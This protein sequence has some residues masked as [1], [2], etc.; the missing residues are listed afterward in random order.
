MS[1]MEVLAGLGLVA[2]EL[3]KY[4]RGNYEF[5]QD[6]RFEREECRLKMQIE[7]FQLFR[8]DIRD[9]VELTVGKMDLYHLIGA[10]FL[11]M[12]VLYYC[13]G[14]FEKTPPPFL[15]N[16]YYLSNAS[17]WVYLMLAIWLAMHASISSH[18]YGTRLLT[19]FVRL[20]IPGSAQLNVLNARYADFEKQG[21]QM[22]RVP[23]VGKEANTWQQRQANG[24][25]AA[26]APKSMDRDSGGSKNRGGTG[27]ASS[28]GKASRGTGASSSKDAGNTEDWLG[29]G[30][31]AYGGIDDIAG[32]EAEMLRAVEFKTHR[33]VQLFRQ[34]QSQ[35]QCYDAYARVCMCL[36]VREMIQSLTYYM[37]GI[38]LVDAQTP[39]VAYALVVSFQALALSLYIL[40]IHGLPCYGNL[41][42]SIVGAAP[43]IIAL[44]QLSIADRSDLGLLMDD[45]T[46]RLSCACFPLEVCWM[47]LSLWAASP[48]DDA[49]AIPRH[50]RSVLF[51][52][53]FS[54]VEDPLEADAAVGA[55]GLN[56][57]ER[58]ALERRI[59]GAE[60]ALYE[61]NAAL[62]RWE[63][64][65]P[66]AYSQAQSRVLKQASRDLE[67]WIQALSRELELRKMPPL[68]EDQQR[69]RRWQD[70]TTGERDDD[71]FSGMVLGPFAHATGSGQESR[72]YF[73]P[74]IQEYVYEPL[75]R[76]RRLLHLEQA[77]G[78]VAGF[79]QEVEA[80]CS[81]SGAR[82]ER[83][84][85]ADEPASDA[86]DSDANSPLERARSAA[87]VTAKSQTSTFKEHQTLRPNRLPWQ[88][89]HFMTRAIQL[90]WIFAFIMTVLRLTGILEVDWQTSPIEHSAEAEEAGEDAH[91]KPASG[92]EPEHGSEAEPGA[93]HRR[94]LLSGG[95][96]GWQWWRPEQRVDVSWP[97]GGFFRPEGLSCL[98]SNR[99]LSGGRG[100][101]LLSSPF[102]LY[103]TVATSDGVADSAL[104]GGIAGLTLEELP[105]DASA[106]GAVALCPAGGAAREQ[107]C[108][109]GA[110]A[111]RGGLDFLELW[112]L[113]KPRGSVASRWLRLEGVPWRR[114]SGALL[115]C[116][117]FAGGGEAPSAELMADAEDHLCVLFAGWRGPDAGAGIEVVLSPLPA[118][119]PAS[120]AAAG[121][122]LARAQLALPRAH[123]T[124]VVAALHVEPSSGR[125]WA[126]L[127]AGPAGGAT[128]L[129]QLVAWDLLRG[130][131]GPIGRW[132]LR[133][134]AARAGSQEGGSSEHRAFAPAGLCTD[135][136]SGDL[137]MTGRGASGPE[138]LRG[139]SPLALAPAMLHPLP[140]I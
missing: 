16:L 103:R 100:D 61:A 140:S 56:I 95:G 10:L 33:H 47:H 34:L 126:A 50:F 40:D 105:G 51:M 108:L 60:S 66:D 65:P 14:F 117:V 29:G 49:N 20:P 114:W 102:A 63:A 89:L 25:L 5:D 64:V 44:I 70:L 62:R 127:V 124:S 4:N 92:S 38:C 78:A 27:A 86:E 41:D 98:P 101:L 30:E 53:V 3:F 35:W 11:K 18:S 83:D 125:L 110:L 42:L 43:T 109:L 87:S 58:T 130:S 46:Y 12:I 88:L 32:R 8:E 129:P 133:A 91:E 81:M 135:E 97:S 90:V 72:Y 85:T 107:G 13:V 74:E 139:P 45:N 111:A 80:V 118:T 79:V 26:D 99:S 138:L 9:L 71:P 115:P 106:P 68:Q 120:T 76:D 128:A 122:A 22:W 59:E 52:D 24:N 119:P 2:T 57:K 94:L 96:L 54:E 48:T 93:E 134:V 131:G 21:M 39:F 55:R 15:L 123:E 7:R 113:E 37:I 82:Q 28:N 73:D 137:F 112:P 77:L 75:P 23:F 6:Q 136:A 132:Q 69:R 17:A 36:G 1:G 104:E 121:V 67:R 19:R 84:G 116:A 31:Y